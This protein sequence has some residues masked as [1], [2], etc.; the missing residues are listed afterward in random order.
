MSNK[1]RRGAREFVWSACL[2]PAR[3]HGKFQATNRPNVRD[4]LQ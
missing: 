3:V 2:Q 1:E 4:A